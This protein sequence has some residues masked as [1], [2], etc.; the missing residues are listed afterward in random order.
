MKEI[1]LNH[2]PKGWMAEFRG[3]ERQTIIN[4]FGTAILPTGF[5]ARANHT[6]VQA[7]IERKNPGYKVW[8]R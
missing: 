7:E 1:V 3:D 6:S 8:V 5:T 2:T 4:L